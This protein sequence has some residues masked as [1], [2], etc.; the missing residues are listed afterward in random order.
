[1]HVK[2]SIK[3]TKIEAV[4]GTTTVT[5]TL[6]ATLAKGEVGLVAKRGASVDLA[7]FTLKK[8]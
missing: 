8:K 3:G 1:V 6:P 4:V 2:I 7:G 5:G